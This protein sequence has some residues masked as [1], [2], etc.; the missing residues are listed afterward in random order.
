RVPTIAHVHDRLP[1]ARAP[2]FML[3]RMVGAVDGLFACSS[4]VAEPLLALNPSTPVRVVY[5]PVDVDR[6]GPSTV[7]REEARS[8]LGLGATTSPRCSAPRTSPSSHHGR[9]RSECA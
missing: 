3:K 6:F 9:S 2:T 8:R 1:Q 5:N 7:S 4:Y